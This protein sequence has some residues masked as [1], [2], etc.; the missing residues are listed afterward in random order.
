MIRQLNPAELP[1]CA[2]AGLQFFKEGKL[3]GEFVPACFIR[4]WSR[5][6]GSGQGVIIA[7]IVGKELRGGLGAIL[8]P[9][10]NNDELIACESFWYVLQNHRGQGARLLFAYERWARERGAK[11]IAMVH[12]ELL[13]PGILGPL[14]E[15]LGYRKIETNYLKDL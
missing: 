2:D 12:L 10:L 15:R 8:C 11:R 1:I 14:Y 4:N 9:D 6:I 7:D 3:P 13:Q 5:L